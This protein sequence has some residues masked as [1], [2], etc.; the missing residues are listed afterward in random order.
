MTPSIMK[1]LPSMPELLLPLQMN[2]FKIN[3]WATI[4]E[5]GFVDTHYDSSLTLQTDLSMY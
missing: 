4:P 5:S 1:C 2:R 3:N